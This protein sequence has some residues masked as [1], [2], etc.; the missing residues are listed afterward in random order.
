MGGGFKRRKWSQIECAQSFVVHVVGIRKPD[1]SYFRMVDLGL[2]FEWSGFRMVQTSLYIVGCQGVDS[3]GA[4]TGHQTVVSNKE[5]GTIQQPSGV[6]QLPLGQDL[7]IIHKLTEHRL[8]HARGPVH[9]LRVR[10]INKLEQIYFAA[11]LLWISK[12]PNWMIFV[13]LFTM[14]PNSLNYQCCQIWCNSTLGNFH[15]LESQISKRRLVKMT[16]KSR[17][18]TWVL[19]L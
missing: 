1:V 3:Q 15:L 9:S 14:L 7:N 4:S 6:V 8:R 13:R 19:G 5:G 18:R 12:Q 2:D 17:I 11:S 16:E 10:Y